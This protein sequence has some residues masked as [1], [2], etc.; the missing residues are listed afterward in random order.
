MAELNDAKLFIEAKR[1]A[2]ASLG[3]ALPIYRVLDGVDIVYD[4]SKAP[5]PESR[6]GASGGGA[7]T[8]SRF[9]PTPF[10][11]A[12]KPPGTPAKWNKDDD[13]EK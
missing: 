5:A 3:G 2:D 11:T 12:P 10:N 6:G 8:G 13:D 9:S 7:Q 1:Q 4:S